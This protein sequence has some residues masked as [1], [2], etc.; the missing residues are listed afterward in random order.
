MDYQLCGRFDKLRNYLPDDLS[1]AK[2][3]DIHS[4]GSIRDY[5]SNGESE[6]IGCKTDLDQINGGCLWLFE[7]NIINNIDSLSKDKFKIII[8]YIIIWLNYMINLKKDGKIN[9][10]NDFYTQYIEKNTYYASCKK[11]DNDC[12]NSLKEQT[13]YNNFKEFIEKNEYLLNINYDDVSKFY[14][15]FKSL[16]NMYTEL[17]ANDTKCDKCLENVKEFVKKYDELN[18]SDITKDSPYYQVLSTLSDDYNNFK[19]YCK[20]NNVD[21]NHIQT[22]S[23]IKIKENGVQGSAHNDVQHFEATSSS[24]S[25]TNKL[26]IVLSIFGA[27]AFFLGISYKYSLFGFRKRT[28]K[29]HLRE[30]IKK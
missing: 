30:K 24:S 5:C 13:G 4:L 6:G 21:C 10:I 18:I 20:V 3:S 16:C 17:D 23:P 22:L 26:F 12:S 25:I 27:I 19:N 9:N 2:N 14:A 28:Q 1:K 7:Q 8:I 29:Q 15:A 11:N